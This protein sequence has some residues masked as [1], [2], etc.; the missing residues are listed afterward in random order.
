M[1]V[2][3]QKTRGK[4]T[5]ISETFFKSFESHMDYI[6]HKNRQIDDQDYAHMTGMLRGGQLCKQL[7]KDDFDEI[8]REF[9]SMAS[10]TYE[11]T[12][13]VT[14]VRKIMESQHGD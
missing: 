5:M 9:I 4:K 2:G 6:G 1:R 10:E 8:I 13:Y 7:S 3:A 11:Y 14:I 12:E